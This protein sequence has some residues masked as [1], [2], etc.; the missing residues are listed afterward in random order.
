ML[1]NNWRE[2]RG[3]LTDKHKTKDRFSTATARKV[4]KK[5]LENVLIMFYH[6]NK[7]ALYTNNVFFHRHMKYLQV[8]E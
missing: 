5:N 1:L 7:L 8:L 2:V 3:F 4:A 6:I